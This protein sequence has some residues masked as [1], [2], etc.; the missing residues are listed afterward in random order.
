MVT[1]LD[2]VGE[3]APLLD[4]EDQLRSVG[5]LGIRH[6]DRRTQVG[7]LDAAA[8]ATAVGALPPERADQIVMNASF[9]NAVA[10]A[11]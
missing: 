8:V 10:R 3:A 7:Y 11:V 1:G 2:A 5:F 4:G 9:S 6:R